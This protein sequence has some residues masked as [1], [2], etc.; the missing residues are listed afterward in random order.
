M[1]TESRSAPAG[2]SPWELPSASPPSVSHEPGV[3]RGARG[4]G[5]ALGAAVTCGGNGGSCSKGINMEFLPH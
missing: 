5:M 1:C 4:R 3:A 2:L